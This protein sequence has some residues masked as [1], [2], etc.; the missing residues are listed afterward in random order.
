MMPNCPR[1]P[2]VAV[3][4]GNNRIKLGWFDSA[5]GAGLPAPGCSLQ[6]TG[7]APDLERIAGWLA[8]RRAAWWIGSVNRPTATRL[9]EWIHDYDPATPVTLLA[10]GDLPLQVAVERPD[11][12][13]IDRLLDAV[14]VNRLRQ[15]DRPAVVVDVGSAITVDLVSANGAFLGGAIAPGIGMSARALHAFTDLLPLVETLELAAPPPA[16]G[17]STLTAM[18]SGLFWGAVGTIRELTARLC[19]ALDQ[20]AEVFLTGGAGPAVAELLGREVRHIP[21]LTLAGIALSVDASH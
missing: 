4:I 2:I 7:E 16:L 18:R 8:G 10:A 21:H 12:V 6:I 5:S 13:G 3:D 9:V 19:A 15:P 11:M 20:T 17:V 14:A 1:F